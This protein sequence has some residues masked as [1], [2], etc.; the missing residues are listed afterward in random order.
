VAELRD[1]EGHTEA[2]T[3]HRAQVHDADLTDEA[4]QAGRQP[5]GGN[6]SALSPVCCSSASRP[7]RSSLRCPRAFSPRGRS[8][9][10]SYP[11]RQRPA[12][13]P[14]DRHRPARARNAEM[15]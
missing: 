11:S 7:R 15:K 12:Q 5:P 8:S 14:V 1:V 4:R 10:S 13:D 6:R 3:G 2:L 9:G